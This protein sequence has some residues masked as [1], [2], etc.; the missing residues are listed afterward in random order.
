MMI[1]M[2]ERIVLSASMLLLASPFCYAKGYTLADA[3]HIIVTLVVIVI[4]LIVVVCYS[5][6]HNRIVSQ[7][8]E[9]LR[10]ILRALDDYRA[11]VGDEVVSLGRRT[12]ARQEPRQNKIPGGKKE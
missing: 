10:R 1:M 4:A 9:Q 5:M 7:R 12:L 8:N 11:K 3:N 2:K 6:H